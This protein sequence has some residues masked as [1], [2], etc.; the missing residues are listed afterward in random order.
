MSYLTLLPI[1]LFE[2]IFDYS[3][4][5]DKSNLYIFDPLHCN[6]IVT[7][8][9]IKNL[10]NTH[11]Q[12]ILVDP[13]SPL[14]AI[15]DLLN[16]LKLKSKTRDIIKFMGKSIHSM[17]F[18]HESYNFIHF[19]T[20]FNNIDKVISK[21]VIARVKN[22]LLE[23]IEDVGPQDMI[24]IRIFRSVSSW[25]IQIKNLVNRSDFGW[26]V[27]SNIEDIHNINDI[28]LK[29]LYNKVNIKFSNS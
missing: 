10:Y 28:I 12:E 11:N 3:S 24:D 7:E 23:R 25:R 21:E 14:M 4:L 22:D 5:E 13:T 16:I 1:E 27:S 20:E 26:A 18:P 29:L 9:Y 8:K 19:D 15:E 17:R 2:I 6:K